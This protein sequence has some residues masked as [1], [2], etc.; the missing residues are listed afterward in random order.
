MVLTIDDAEGHA[1]MR[2]K[3]MCGAK[4]RKGTSCQCKAMAN[5]RCKYHGGMSTGPKTKEGKMRAL[6]NLKQCR[7]E[8]IRRY[9]LGDWADRFP[10]KSGAAGN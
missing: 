9:I 1:L 3:I 4:T 10:G 6:A 5:G 2:R 7:S 8:R